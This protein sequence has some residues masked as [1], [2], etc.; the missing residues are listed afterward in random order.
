MDATT[1]KLVDYTMCVRYEDLPRY[2]RFA[3]QMLAYII[4]IGIAVFAVYACDFRTGRDPYP[5]YCQDNPC[6]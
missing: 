2:K 1:E 6:D 5:L 4:V 3:N